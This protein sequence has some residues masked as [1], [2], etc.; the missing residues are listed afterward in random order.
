MAESIKELRKICQ[1]GIPAHWISRKIYFP[2]SILITSVVIRTPISANAVTIVGILMWLS[3]CFLLT[4]LKTG[5]QITA[6]ILFQLGFLFDCVD[7]E[8]ARY[9]KKEG[10]GGAYLDLLGHHLVSP[11]LFMCWGLSI[12]F[13]LGHIAALYIG[14]IGAVV[15]YPSALNTKEHILITLFQRNLLKPTTDVVQQSM[16]SQPDLSKIEMSKVTKIGRILS[17][18]TRVA[19]P[20]REF[21]GAPGCFISIS[22][23]I[24]L[25][26]IFPPFYIFGYLFNFKLL[27]LCFHVI[28]LTINSL[29]NMIRE[30]VVL[31]RLRK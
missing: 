30:F 8:V 18:L 15:I 25:D 19:Q 29:K 7:G 13:S 16:K 31:E 11:L 22:I 4:I 6:A 27:M 14:M 17:Y 26:L 2:F 21:F 28:P 3:A 12:F 9:R 10:Y 24:I 1:G 23:A 5:C 20:F